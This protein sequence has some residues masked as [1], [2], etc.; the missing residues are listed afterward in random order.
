MMIVCFV[1]AILS[2]AY[3]AVVLTAGS[4][5]G[6]CA[7]WFAIS[8]AFA[9]L[10]V[11]IRKKIWRKFTKGCKCA[12]IAVAAVCLAVFAVF[13]GC[14]ISKMNSDGRNGLDYVIVLGAQVYESGPSRVLK[15]RLDKAAE[16]LEKNPDT[17]C[18]VSGGQGSNEPF[19]EAV[20]MAKYLEKNG[21]SAERIIVE[22]KSKTTEQNIKNS[23]AFISKNSSVGV[24]TNNFHLYRALQICKKAGLDNVCGIAAGSTKLFLPNNMLR[25]FLAEIKFVIRAII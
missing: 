23:M 15:Y 8:A 17:V 20:G 24:I 16:Y 19:A 25:E 5:T 14:V 22:D 11:F 3:G 9:A 12:V 13:E 1:F 10:G 6:F 18:I 21:V 7:V 2:A 4:G